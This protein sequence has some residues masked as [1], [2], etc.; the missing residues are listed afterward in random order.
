M[1]MNMALLTH[2]RDQYY[3]TLKSL[4]HIYISKE[5]FAISGNSLLFNMTCILLKEIFNADLYALS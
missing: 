5:G 4:L 3:I 2:G 1:C